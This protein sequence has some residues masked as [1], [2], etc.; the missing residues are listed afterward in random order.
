MRYATAYQH[1]KQTERTVAKTRRCEAMT[2]NGTEEGLLVRAEPLQWAEEISQR[3]VDVVRVE[4][5]ALLLE[6]DP[7]WAAAINT[8]L[9]AKGVR[10]NELRRETTAGRL[11]G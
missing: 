7:G 6:A 4:D 5:G 3:M 8:V 10:V 11:T 2:E 9:V 1:K